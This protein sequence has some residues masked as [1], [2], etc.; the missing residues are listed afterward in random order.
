MN[1]YLNKI[2]N[3]DQL[4]K[5]TKALDNWYNPKT[6]IKIAKALLNEMLTNIKTKYDISDEKLQEIDEELRLNILNRN[7]KYFIDK[8]FNGLIT[9]YKD[10][11]KELSS[12]KKKQIKEDNKRNNFYINEEPLNLPDNEDVNFE[13]SETK[14]LKYQGL[15]T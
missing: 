13:V 8:K 10:I 6:S 2:N 9:D 15:K 3:L 4:F 7:K 5:A 14:N 11:I 12:E 1:I